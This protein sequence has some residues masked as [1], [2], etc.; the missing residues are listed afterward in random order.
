MSFIH[1]Y[2]VVVGKMG[3]K[4]L[5]HKT[6]S[7]YSMSYSHYH[8]VCH[9]FPTRSFQLRPHLM[10][11]EKSPTRKKTTAEEDNIPLLLT[12]V[13]C[14]LSRTLLTYLLIPILLDKRS[15]RPAQSIKY[16]LRYNI[17]IINS[18]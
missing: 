1:L 3:N 17:E 5:C 11:K 14:L 15:R 8:I 6:Y 2:L 13:T 18:S 4:Y 9:F 7:K 10:N 12:D 16:G